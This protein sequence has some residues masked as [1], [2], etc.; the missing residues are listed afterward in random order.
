MFGIKLTKQ[1]FYNVTYPCDKW[2]VNK[3]D[4]PIGTDLILSKKKEEN[5]SEREIR[6]TKI[7]C[8]PVCPAIY[9]TTND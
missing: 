6:F 2:R 1:L 4:V 9:Y 5:M 7:E 3:I 8:C